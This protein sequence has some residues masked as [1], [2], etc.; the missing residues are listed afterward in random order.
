MK[1]KSQLSKTILL[2]LFVLP[3]FAAATVSKFVGEQ[4]LNIYD[5]KRDRKLITEIWYPTNASKRSA[6]HVDPAEEVF[7]REMKTIEGAPFSDVKKHPLILISHGTG[8][9][10]ESLQ[11][12]AVALAQQNYIVA[13]ADHF[14]STLDN[15]DPEAVVKFWEQPLDITCVL[16]FLLD[17]S[18]FKNLIDT[19]KIG[20][21]G[22]S[23][24]G[25]TVLALAGAQISLKA[26]QQFV[27]TPE[28]QKEISISEMS[29]LSDMFFEKELV[30]SFQQAPDLMDS[31][32]KAVMAFAPAVGQGF[33][34]HDQ[35]ARIKIPVTIIGCA[36]D[37]IAPVMYNAMHYLQ[38]IQYCEYEE[39][40]GEA[41][42]Y[43]FLP[44]ATAFGKQMAAQFCVDA[45][46]VNRHLIH[47]VTIARAVGFFN[48][49]LQWNK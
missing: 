15:P 34:S 8:G 30:L 19:G 47:Q 31:R 36:S 45:P 10:R 43:V 2:L 21:A 26:I 42:H 9:N 20:A 40:K 22:F 13:A 37:S 39:Y 7:I 28:G 46:S 6:S 25:Y 35:F 16:T 49:N 23:I 27:K 29:G 3:Q 41:G 48:K 24:G 38:L 14:G 32:I 5:Y 4:T 18:S 11:W 12:L 33:T 44:E 17:S 1:N